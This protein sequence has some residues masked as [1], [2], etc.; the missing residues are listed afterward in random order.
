MCWPLKLIIIASR[1]HGFLI[2]NALWECQA[3]CNGGL[4]IVVP[5]CFFNELKAI[6]KVL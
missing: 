2:L 1:I 6:L 5:Q 4:R 3:L